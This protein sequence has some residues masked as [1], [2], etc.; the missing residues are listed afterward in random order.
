MIRCSPYPPLAHRMM[1][2]EGSCKACL[3]SATRSMSVAAKR[4]HC[5]RA[6]APTLTLYPHAR[7]RVAVCSI[8][9][10]S[11]APEG[12]IIWIWKA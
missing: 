10:G 6:C 12:E 5:S 1:S 11:I 4:P 8:S 7:K 2:I 3:Q 9:M